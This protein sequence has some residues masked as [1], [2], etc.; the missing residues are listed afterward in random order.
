[1]LQ[2]DGSG[3]R[4]GG[5][6]LGLSY[7]SAA[8]FVAVR[9]RSVC[10]NLGLDFLRRSGRLMDHLIPSN[11]P[12]SVDHECHHNH[13]HSNNCCPSPPRN[14]SWRVLLCFQPGKN[15][16]FESGPG[17][18]RGVLC[19]RGVKLIIQSGRLW[20]VPIVLVIGHSCLFS[21]IRSASFSR[22]ICRA[23]NTRD[24]TAASL[25]PNVAATS[26]GDISS[27]VESTSGSRSFLGKAAINR[28][29]IAPIWT[30]CTASSAGDSEDVTSSKGF[31]GSSRATSPFRPRCLLRSTATR[32]AMRASHVLWSSTDA[33]LLLY[34]STR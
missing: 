26:L 16:I 32:Q 27:I 23:R 15:P 17:L 30:P 12:H 1:M 18:D 19:K 29:S 13:R 7:G 24:R 25:I 5:L 8:G 20:T 21:P 22:K 4:L 6:P 9:T 3:Y 11:L 14:R 33:S 10:L 34:R 28:C 31:S 2:L